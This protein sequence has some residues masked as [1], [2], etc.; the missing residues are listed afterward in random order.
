[1]AR[2]PTVSGRRAV[3]AL[4]RAGFTIDRRHGSHMIMI[5]PGHPYSLSLFPTIEDSRRA[6]SEA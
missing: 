5:K 2:L 3:S 1:M 6:P 4:E